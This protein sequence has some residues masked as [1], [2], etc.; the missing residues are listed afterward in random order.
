MRAVLLVPPAFRCLRVHDESGNGITAA[1]RSM[2]VTIHSLYSYPVKSC[3]G[4]EHTQASISAAGLPYDRNW[5]I[6]DGRGV[7]MTQRSCARMALIRPALDAG[8]LH[9]SAPGMPA[10]Q[11]PLARSGPAPEAVP[12]KIW[13]SDTL[14]ADEG[15]AVAQW[16]GRCLGQ[17]CR[18]L[19]VHPR[20]ARLASADYVG[21]WIHKHQDWAPDFPP[22][23]QFAFADGYPFLVIGQASLDDLNHRLAERGQPAVPMNRFRPSIVVQGLEPYEE[24][25]LAGMNVGALRFAFVKRC[26]RCP[27]PNIDQDTA[28]AADEPGLTLIRYRSFDEGVLFGVN[29]VMAGTAAQIRVGDAVE[30]EFDL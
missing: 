19:R 25:Y 20:A 4:I 5:V 29:A 24:D 17:P 10:M 18:L 23:H 7:F 30:P 14:G 1:H 3:A 21:P 15:E 16:L 27:I 12:V 2:P 26:A 9:L 13:K 22:D 11:V 8:H 28:I 6:V